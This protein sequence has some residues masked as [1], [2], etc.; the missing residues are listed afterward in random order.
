MRLSP[1]GCWAPHLGGGG[2]ASSFT[3]SEDAFRLVYL[4][5]GP[6]GIVSA[7]LLTTVEKQNK[8]RKLSALFLLLT[9]LTFKIN[10]DSL[11]ISGNPPIGREG[12]GEER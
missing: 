1:G 11:N 5:S 7:F 3:L 2:V 6:G 10:K 9:H 4:P 12:M 8:N